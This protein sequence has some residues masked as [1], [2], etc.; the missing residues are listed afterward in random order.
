MSNDD[1]PEQSAAAAAISV[2]PPPFTPNKTRAYFRI[3]EAQFGNARITTD[4][5]KCRH[6]ISNLPADVVDELSDEEIE[7]NNF[8]A[9]K[10]RI[11]SLYGKS[12]P[13]VFNELLSLPS[14]IQTKPSLYLQQLRSKASQLNLTD[15]F[16]KIYFIKALPDNIKPALITH[17][18]DLDQLASLADNL[19]DYNS[20]FNRTQNYFSQPQFNVAQI[21][22]N[23]SRPS[24]PHN[25]NTSVAPSFPSFCNETIP[26]NIRSFNSS[27]K[28]QI[29]RYHLW[30]GR[31]AKRC[32]PW[33]AMNDNSL[34]LMPNS[35]APSRSSSPNR[36]SPL[37]NAIGSQ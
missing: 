28:P 25:V 1:G 15:D 16:L 4:D 31:R 35:R 29:C 30:Y 20:P 37:G 13:E 19:M 14:A 7:S 32:K 23:V 22:R 26:I 17:N 6:L 24:R 18:G 34:P 33:C 3:L 2:R 8:Q 36:N 21:N 9:F 27:Q 5:T 11:I 12:T 10:D